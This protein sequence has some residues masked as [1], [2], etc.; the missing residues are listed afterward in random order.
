VA[1][2]RYTKPGRLADV[3]ALIQVLALDPHAHRSASGLLA[4]L[5]GNPS[6]ADCWAT[7]ASQHPEFFRVVADVEHGISLVAR[8]VMPGGKGDGRKLDV[9]FIAKLITAAIDLHDRE[10][11]QRTFWRTTGATLL[12]VVL[13]GS[14]AT[15]GSYFTARFQAENQSRLQNAAKAQEVYSR[16]MGRKFATEQ[17]YTSRYEAYIFS[18]YHEALWKLAGAPA[19]SLD[20][21]EAQRWMHR[22]EDLAMEIMKSNQ[23]L[24]EDLG[25]VRETFGDQAELRNLVASL[26]AIHALKTPPTPAT[27]DPKVL[28]SWR[29]ESVKQVQQIAE[30]DYAKRF[31]D[32]LTYLF[33]HLNN[34]HQP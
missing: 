8:H 16:L 19:S 12:A 23:A 17:L 9:D 33:Q 3:L 1:T 18:D 4:D 11:S 7:V 13:G 31:D 21:Q 30:Q 28:A 29:D 32:L 2:K 20:L 26:S 10:Q 15:A 5:Q 24:Y 27:S 22:S 6:S 34:A 25:V 14:V